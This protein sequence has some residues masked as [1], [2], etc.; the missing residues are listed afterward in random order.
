MRPR[1]NQPTGFRPSGGRRSSFFYGRRH[2][3]IY[4]PVAWI[5]TGTGRSYEKGYY[6]E[7][8][9]YYDNVVFEENG[10]YSNVVC[11][12]PYCGQDS[13]LD[14]SSEQVAAQS[15]QCP[16]CG[17]PMEIK[18]ELDQ[19]VRGNSPD[20]DPYDTVGKPRKKRRWGWWILGILVFLYLLGSWEL[21][22][23]EQSLQQLPQNGTQQIYEIDDPWQSNPDLFGE[24]VSLVSAG[25]NAFRIA[26]SSEAS[27]RKMVWDA[28]E[29][30]YYEAESD[31]WIWYNTDVEPPVWQYWYEGISSDF[32]DYGWMEHDEDGWFI[33]ASHGN[34][35]E[36]PARYDASRLWYIEP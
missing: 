14:L 8:G 6:D 28:D 5:D 3:Y 35:V 33:E 12:C 11:H 26:S 29:D 21:K 18:S 15:L 25:G 32:G 13:I 9:Q 20:S 4:Y 24:T 10:R 23:E 1:T 22:K 27:G 16:H 36:L 19:A 30:S 31:C 7:T 34:W 2:Q 17:G